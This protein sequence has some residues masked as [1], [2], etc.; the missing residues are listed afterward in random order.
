MQPLEDIKIYETQ[1]APMKPEL[2]PVGYE[3][4]EFS[5]HYTDMFEKKIL[6]LRSENIMQSLIKI[7]AS[8]NRLI[9]IV[10]N[11]PCDRNADPVVTLQPTEEYNVSES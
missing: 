3:A 4:E 7:E 10:Q 11:N 9:E 5:G 8:L 2:R 6:E 1:D